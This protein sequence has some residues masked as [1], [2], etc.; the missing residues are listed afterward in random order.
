V[1]D[2]TRLY[3]TPIHFLDENKALYPAY[4]AQIGK[5]VT[6]CFQVKGDWPEY[7]PCKTYAGGTPVT[8][9][10][11]ANVEGWRTLEVQ[12]SKEPYVEICTILRENAKEYSLGFCPS[13]V[14]VQEGTVPQGTSSSYVV[15]LGPKNLFYENTCIFEIQGK[16]RIIKG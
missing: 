10:V 1:P 7:I 12:R 2:P 13:N 16:S 9:Q 15:L 4:N 3:S 11:Y 6:D 8:P 14:L 5:P